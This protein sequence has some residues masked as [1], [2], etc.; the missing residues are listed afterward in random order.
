VTRRFS[1]YLARRALDGTSGVALKCRRDELWGVA[2]ATVTFGTDGSVAKVNIGPPFTDTPAG[3]CVAEALG[4][5]RVP[6]FAGRPAVFV[7]QFFVGR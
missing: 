2:H 6:A 5:A 3:D 7:Y 1:P 4:A